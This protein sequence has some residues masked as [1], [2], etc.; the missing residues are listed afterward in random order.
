MKLRPFEERDLAAYV[1][2]GNRCYPEYAWSL[3]SARHEEASWTDPKFFR[4]R[5]MLDDDRGNAVAFV[6]LHHQRGYFD[7]ARYRCEINVDPDHRRRGYGSAPFERAVAAAR[8]RDGRLVIGTAKESMSESVAFLTK[9]GCVER[10]RA[11]ESRL[12]IDAFDLAKFKDAEPRVA[13]QGV[14]ITTLTDEMRRDRDAALRGAYEI[15][16]LCRADIPS[17]DR[18]TKHSFVSFVSELEGPDS[19]HDGFF[20]AVVDGE[21]VGVSD[22]WRDSGNPAGLYQGL[23]GVAPA[24]RGKGIAMA[25]KLQTVKYARANGKKLIKTWN[26]TRNLPMLRI[27]EA[28]GFARQPAWIEFEKRL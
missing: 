9:R 2:I 22:L 14:R 16:E 6:L 27:N 24:H 11:W 25:L 3:A 19:L 26:D 20:L 4:A 7:A 13:K 10:Q 1:A 5:W 21:Y 18:A 17:A 12:D 23:T 28:M 15:V 8:E